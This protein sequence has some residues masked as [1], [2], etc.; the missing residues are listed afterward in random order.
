MNDDEKI[1]LEMFKKHN[2]NYQLYYH[3]AVFAVGDAP[4]LQE[5]IPG[6]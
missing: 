5:T 3:E 2:F 6:Y 1:L 4:H